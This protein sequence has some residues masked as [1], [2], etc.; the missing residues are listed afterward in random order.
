VTLE[1]RYFSMGSS[2]LTVPRFTIS[3]NNIAVNVFVRE[4]ISKIVSPFT[5]VLFALDMFPKPETLRSSII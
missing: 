1:G 3:A 5:L 4:P 2:K